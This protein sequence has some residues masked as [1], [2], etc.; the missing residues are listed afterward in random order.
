MGDIGHITVEQ[1]VMG[2]GAA[3]FLGSLGSDGRI[4][5]EFQLNDPFGD[6]DDLTLLTLNGLE[7]GDARHPVELDRT[8]VNSEQMPMDLG[9]HGFFF[10]GFCEGLSSLRLGVKSWRSADQRLLVSGDGCLDDGRRFEFAAACEFQ[11]V[12]V[13]GDTRAS[14]MDQVRA[15][16]QVE[17]VSRK[18]DLR[19]SEVDGGRIACAVYFADKPPGEPS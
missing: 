10:D 9:E 18:L 11:G 3:T 17:E 5:W 2:L 15:I 19:W 16:W 4:L 14:V 8:R 13:V 7:L 6:E 12:R 1:E